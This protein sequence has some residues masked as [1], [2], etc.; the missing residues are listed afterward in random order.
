M[1]SDSRDK[2]VPVGRLKP[3][4]AQARSVILCILVELRSAGVTG[5][6]VDR[7]S[8]GVRPHTGLLR[9]PGSVGPASRCPTRGG[10]SAHRPDSGYTRAM[11]YCAG[12]EAERRSRGAETCTEQTSNASSGRHDEDVAAVACERGPAKQR[13]PEQAPTAT[14]EYPLLRWYLACWQGTPGRYQMPVAAEK[15]HERRR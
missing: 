3:W 1:I 9:G 5:L 11:R 7:P 8:G 15:A 4:Q 14:F 6:L 13:D 12:Q 2:R 10:T